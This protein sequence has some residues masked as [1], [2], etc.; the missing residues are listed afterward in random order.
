MSNVQPYQ[1]AVGKPATAA[2]VHPWVAIL[3]AMS[4]AMIGFLFCLIIEMLFDI[5]LSK[6]VSSII[7]FAVACF[8]LFYLFPKLY[9]SPFG[10]IPLKEYLQRLGFFLPPHAWRHVLLGILLAGCTLSGMLA[11]SILTGRYVLDWGQIN[12][13]Q[14]VFSL[15]PGIFEEAFYR[16]IIMIL[17]LQMTKSLKKAALG[18]IVIFGLAH[19]KGFDPAT[20]FDIISVMII[21]VAFTYAAYKTRA[22]L[23]GIVFHFLHDS[24]LF[25]VQVPGGKYSGL[26]ENF[27]FYGLLW[28][29]VG[30]GCFIIWYAAERLNVRGERE[31]YNP[32]VA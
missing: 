16:G 21:A 29:M 10:P 13:T 32:G 28:L 23:A 31:L 20:L 19:I 22:L 2:K 26:Q 5:E 25:F 17:L 12:L 18:Q 14:F 15:S 9:A 11:A 30:A 24:F 27:L 7:N 1:K 8:G 4:W 6:L 3:V